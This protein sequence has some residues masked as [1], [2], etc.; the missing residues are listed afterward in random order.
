MNESTNWLA[1]SSLTRL[2]PV[3]WVERPPASLARALRR[4]FAQAL[5]TPEVLFCKKRFG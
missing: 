4:D 5:G 2:C 3:D 1:E